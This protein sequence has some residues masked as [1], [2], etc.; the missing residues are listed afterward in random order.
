MARNK[1]VESVME[2]K[3]FDTVWNFLETKFGYSKQWRVAFYE[4]VY[5]RSQHISYKP[6]PVADFL[7]FCTREIYPPIK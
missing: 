4:F 7:F 5:E 3:D 2:E 6:N 1:S